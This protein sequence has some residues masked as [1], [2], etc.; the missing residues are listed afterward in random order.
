MQSQPC[1]E[2]VHLVPL[3]RL[4]V[5][6]TVLRDDFGCSDTRVRSL[7][8]VV[9]SCVSVVW[10]AV[11]CVADLRSESLG[12]EAARWNGDA[13]HFK[14]DFSVAVELIPLTGFRSVTMR[15]CD[16]EDVQAPSWYGSQAQAGSDLT[17]VEANLC[18]F[19]AFGSA[20]TR[21]LPL[22]EWPEED[23]QDLTAHDLASGRV[24]HDLSCD[25][26]TSLNLQEVLIT[27]DDLE[28]ILCKLR[29]CSIR[30][31]ILG[32][33]CKRN[34]TSLD[35]LVG[36]CSHIVHREELHE[37]AVL[38]DHIRNVWS[39]LFTDD[40]VEDELVGGSLAETTL[41]LEEEENLTTITA[42]ITL[43]VASFGHWEA[44]LHVS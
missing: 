11:T 15:Q 24:A 39:R 30:C 14:A 5:T 8:D 32:V 21:C 12:E 29:I 36:P 33:R 25:T 7:P 44:L 13:S 19:H 27:T 38:Y 34:D 42:R 9:P 2:H 31:R 20:G 40:A 43:V 26:A 17:T 10:K 22:C 28:A 3:E 37:L 35:G 41:P 1:V 16:L 23:P 4:L 18:A 6:S